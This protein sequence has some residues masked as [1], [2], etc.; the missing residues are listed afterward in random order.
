MIATP[1]AAIAAAMPAESVGPLLA[2]LGH[3]GTKYRVLSVLDEVSSGSAQLMN[4]TSGE[5]E[6][7]TCDLVVVQTG[8]ASVDGLPA[9]LRGS[10]LEVH[11]VGDC[12]SPR[13]VSHALLEA[14]RVARAL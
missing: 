14:H 12:V 10:G 6:Q 7:V 9:T 13:R 5:V 2:R 4:A 11:A 3:G 8:R 1:S